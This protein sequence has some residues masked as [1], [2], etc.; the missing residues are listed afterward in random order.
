MWVL[1]LRP[2]NEARL[3]KVG[4]DPAGFE[5]LLGS[6]AEIRPLTGGIQLVLG[7]DSRGAPPNRV[8]GGE[9]V[10]GVCFLCGASLYGLTDFPRE[11][12]EEYR[13]KLDRC[14]LS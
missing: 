4:S 12:A 9:R 10:C 5:A 14:R 13:R 11:L 3:E 2:G 1:M 7:R 6:P 8:I